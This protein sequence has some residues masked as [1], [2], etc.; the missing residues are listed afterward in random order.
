MISPANVRDYCWSLNFS[1]RQS[2][3]DALMRPLRPSHLVGLQAAAIRA[4]LGTR[5][6]LKN[7]SGCGSAAKR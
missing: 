7:D 4:A 1:Q 5:S 3:P 2:F 6:G